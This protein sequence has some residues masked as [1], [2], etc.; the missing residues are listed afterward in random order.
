MPKLVA[1]VLVKNYVN[2][3]GFYSFV[4]SSHRQLPSRA[5]GEG[6]L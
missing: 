2:T 3:R 1:C 5:I 4:S 6:I